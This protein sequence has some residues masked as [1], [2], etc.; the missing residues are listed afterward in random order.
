MCFWM[1]FI[2]LI[3]LIN[4]NG[5]VLNAINKKQIINKKL[6]NNVVVRNN[7]LQNT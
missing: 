4:I 6:S 7:E 1:N 3:L 2:I 5:C